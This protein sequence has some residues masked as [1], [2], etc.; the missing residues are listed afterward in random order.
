MCLCCFNLTRSVL[1]LGS[2]VGL[3]GLMCLKFKKLKSFVFSDS[4]VLVI[5]QIK[6]NLDLNTEKHSNKIFENDLNSISVDRIDWT[7]ING[8]ECTGK[9]DIDLIIATGKVIILI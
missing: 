1:E 5:K 4:H 3:L 7:D 6:N 2:G 8:D 9:E